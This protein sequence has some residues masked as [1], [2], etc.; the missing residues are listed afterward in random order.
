MKKTLIL[1]FWIVTVLLTNT[2][3]QN[4]AL[5]WPI[6]G[7]KH[8]ENILFRPNDVIGNETNI[9]N[10]FIHAKEGSNVLAPCDGIIKSVGDIRY[11]YKTSLFFESSAVYD[12]NKSDDYQ[13]K[14]FADDYYLKNRTKIDSKYISLQ[15][16]ITTENDEKYYIHGLRPKGGIK[17][18]TIIKQGNYIGSVAY[19][20]NQI[21]EPSICISRKKNGYQADPMSPFGLKSTFKTQNRKSLNPLSILP[22]SQYKEDFQIFRESLEEGHPGLHDYISKESLDSLF[23]VTYST[24]KEGLTIF[25]FYT[26]LHHIVYSIRDSHTQLSPVSNPIQ[27][28]K[29]TM[30]SVLFGILNDSLVVT[31]VSDSK[32]LKYLG[33]TITSIDNRPAKEIIYKVKTKH[34][35][36]AYSSEGFIKSAYD[37]NLAAFSYITYYNIF[38]TGDKTLYSLKFSDNT[39]VNFPY[40]KE[41]I[42]ILDYIPKWKYRYVPKL[43]ISFRQVDKNTALLSINS[44]SLT[45][46][47]YDS[48]RYFIKDIS[49]KNI[50]NLIIDLRNNSGGDF[51][52]LFEYFAKEPFKTVISLKVNQNNTYKFFKYCS[53]YTIYDENIFPEYIKVE[54][55][56]GYHYPT[57]SLKTYHP[58]DSINYDGRIYVLT[59]EKSISA[60]SIFAGLIHKYKRG[61][62]VGRETGSAYQQLNAVKFANVRLKNTELSLRIPL[63]KCIYEYPENSDI[64]WGRGVLPDYP[65]KITLDELI[66]DK[67]T[68]LNYTLQLIKEDKYINSENIFA[69]NQENNNIDKTII[70]V[71][72]ALIGLV[73]ILLIALLKYMKQRDIRTK[74][75]QTPTA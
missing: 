69:E 51:G 41:N 73:L 67:D 6:E 43:N 53:N 40:I 65:F 57:D 26:Q 20:Y 34:I 23:N 19:C 44:F 7:H 33:K 9:E 16:T 39:E 50:N 8:G 62:I 2:F 68:M 58:S 47:D 60:A 70:I 5:T 18:G 27:N 11:V 45:E 59:N 37:A 74:K 38:P 12:S 56:A 14:K 22:S 17:S 42:S 75:N 35:Q 28:T 66:G 71:T 15:I 13:R 49:K 36:S 31:M 46:T 21:K 64:P 52:E 54:G 72:W 32:Y 25:D 10:F 4:S 1:Q 24:I 61:V 29:A 63:V 55:K 48:I 3:A 30:P